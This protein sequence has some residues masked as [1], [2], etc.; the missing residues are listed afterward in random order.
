MIC[1]V[2]TI[3]QGDKPKS[4]RPSYAPVLCN[5]TGKMYSPCCVKECKE[6]HVVERYGIGGKAMVSIYVCRKCKHKVKTPF[7]GAL[8][9][10]YGLEQRVQEGE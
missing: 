10:G 8:G 2:M 1:G 3:G 6:P 9:C 5:V 7:C 4:F